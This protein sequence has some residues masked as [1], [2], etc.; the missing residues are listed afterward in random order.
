[1]LRSHPAYQ[2]NRRAFPVRVLFD[3][4]GH[5][6]LLGASH[7]QQR[8]SHCHSYL[9]DLFVVRFSSQ[10]EISAFAENSARSRL[11]LLEKLAFGSAFRIAN[12]ALIPR[13]LSK[14]E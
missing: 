5:V 9:I 7:L 10:A 14:H 1:M 12:I 6:R 11:E 2:S 8:Q 3:L 4:Q 13:R